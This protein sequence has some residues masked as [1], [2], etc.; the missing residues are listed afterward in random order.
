M[1]VGPGMG[2]GCVALRWLDALG[3]L[4]PQDAVRRQ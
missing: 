1:W 3:R 2:C 4:S